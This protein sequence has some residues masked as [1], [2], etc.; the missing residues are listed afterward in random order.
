MNWIDDIWVWVADLLFGVQ[1]LFG[2][3][4]GWFAVI[5]G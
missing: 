2:W 3:V 4:F 5:G 1:P